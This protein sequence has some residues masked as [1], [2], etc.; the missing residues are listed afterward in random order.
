M[1]LGWLFASPPERR[2]LPGGRFS[3]P[4][5]FVIAIM[6]FVILIVTAAGLALAN[7]AA[8]VRS[9]IEH[10][11]TVQLP[12][13]A[14]LAAALA[15]ARAVPGVRDVEAVP[16]AEMRRTLEQW[17]GPAG[18]AGDLPVPALL[19]LDL[20]PG[21]DAAAIGRRI[22]QQVPGARFLAHGEALGPLLRSLGALKWLALGL[23]ALM[24]IATSAAVVLAARGA[25][26]THRATIEI[27]H[28]I[29]A[30]DLQVTRL[31]QRKI[32]L[33]ALTGS[34]SGGAAAA[35]VLVLLGGGA[36]VAELA[37]RPPLGSRDLLLLALLPFVIAGLATWVA[38]TAVLAAL[39]RSP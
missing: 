28:G 18:A 13:G 30:T 9:G 12:P 22:A 27:M 21:A 7:A 1:M 31:F 26:D 32:A 17:L 39:R 25:L 36:A 23:V 10:R 16:E 3:G 24:T 8:V 11:Y 6:T 29:G 15:R 2:L 19:T 5:P 4:T 14:P 20:A 37:G 34:I 38:R 35:L 33:D